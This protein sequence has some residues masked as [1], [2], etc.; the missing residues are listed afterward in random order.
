VTLEK[1]FY[2]MHHDVHNE[3]K[4]SA[5]MLSIFYHT[6]STAFDYSNLKLG[7][8]FWTTQKIRREGRVNSVLIIVC[9]K[10]LKEKICR[11]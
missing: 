7:I 3:K 1:Q 10:K 9:Q 4:C 2:K 6:K 8:L 5:K 11:K